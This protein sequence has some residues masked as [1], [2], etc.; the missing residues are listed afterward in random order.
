MAEHPSAIKK[1]ISILP[2]MEKE[3]IRTVNNLD[4]EEVVQR[5]QVLNGKFSAKTIGKLS[6]ESTRASCHDDIVDIE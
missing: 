2:L 1:L 3:A 4:A 6:K 5:T